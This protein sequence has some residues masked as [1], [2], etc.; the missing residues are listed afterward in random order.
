MVRNSHYL[1]LIFGIVLFL[2]TAA[3]IGMTIF[4]VKKKTFTE[5]R[6]LIVFSLVGLSVV[7]LCFVICFLTVKILNYSQENTN[8]P[9]QGVYTHYLEECRSASE[10]C[11]K[12]ITWQSRVEHSAI[13]DVDV[14]GFYIKS[15]VYYH[16]TSHTDTFLGLITDAVYLFH[17][18]FGQIPGE[19]C[20]EVGGGFYTCLQVSCSKR[21][22]G[23]YID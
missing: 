22:G 18:F 7:L 2:T 14:P 8:K 10:S 6:R 11:S 19:V 23:E 1:G 21:I 9:D 15:G 17:P 3:A 20:N 5:K 4:F 12:K 16:Q 13:T